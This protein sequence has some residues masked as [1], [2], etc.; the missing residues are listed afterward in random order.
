MGVYDFAATTID[1]TEQS[2]SGYKGKTLLERK[3]EMAR[4][5]T[6]HISTITNI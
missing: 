6:H 3:M 4:M 5:G 2:L 1:G